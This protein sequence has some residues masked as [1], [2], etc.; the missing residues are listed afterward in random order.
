M[1][2][3]FGVCSVKTVGSLA[4]HSQTNNLNIGST[5]KVVQN[6]GATH[7]FDSVEQPKS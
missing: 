7:L 4:K 6:S 3:I 5:Y 1:V 2:F